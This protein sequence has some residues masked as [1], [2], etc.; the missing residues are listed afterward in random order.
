[1]QCE[2]VE[3]PGGIAIVCGPRRAGGR[4]RV[5]RAP[6]RKQCDYPTAPPT[7]RLCNGYMCDTHAVHVGEDLDWCWPCAEADAKAGAE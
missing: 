4:C 5:C 2:R 1:M 3:I 7:K 6:A